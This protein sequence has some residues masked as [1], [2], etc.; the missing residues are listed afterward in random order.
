MKKATLV[1]VIAVVF[2]VGSAFGFYAL[3]TLTSRQMHVLMFTQE[4][5]CSPT[6]WGAPWDVVL[7]GQT[8]KAAPI[9]AAL[10]IPDTR[11]TANQSNKNF[12]TIGFYVPNGVY[13]YSVSPGDFF[14]DGAVTVNGADAIVTVNGPSIGCTTTIAPACVLAQQ[15]SSLYVKI[16]L[17]DGKTPVTNATV[18]ATPVETCNGV[19]TTIA[20]I[21][22]PVVNASGVAT[23]DASGS[24][25]YSV[26]VHYGSQSYPFSAYVVHPERSVRNSTCANIKLPSGSLSVTAC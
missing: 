23:L 12:S 18:D 5:A 6:V 22:H 16:T 21:Y 25:F 10:P 11:I 15:G 24:T 3:P 2:L 13:T 1:S 26:T 4:G 17:D 20:I 7:N 9:N 14:S 8:T 19:N